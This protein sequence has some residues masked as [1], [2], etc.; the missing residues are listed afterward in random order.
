MEYKR[1]MVTHRLIIFSDVVTSVLLLTA[2]I[3]WA[4]AITTALHADFP[5]RAV[6]AF[7]VYNDFGGEMRIF[8]PR[9]VLEGDSDAAA[10]SRQDDHQDLYVL[11]ALNSALRIYDSLRLSSLVVRAAAVLGMMVS[12]I[13][14]SSA[15]G[16]LQKLAYTLKGA[17][18]PILEL[19]ISL[20]V[21]GSLMAS[22][23][24]TLYFD[25]SQDMSYMRSTL[26]TITGYGV[27]GW[28]DAFFAKI[29]VPSMEFTK[30]ESHVVI[31]VIRYLTPMLMY[32]LYSRLTI[33]TI[34]LS[35]RRVKHKLRTR[36]ADETYTS[37]WKM[38]YEAYG[39]YWP[40]PTKASRAQRVVMCLKAAQNT[41]NL[42]GLIRTIQQAA[43]RKQSKSES[44][45]SPKQ[46]RQMLNVV[47]PPDVVRFVRTFH[48]GISASKAPLGRWSIRIRR[49]GHEETYDV[50]ELMQVIIFARQ[51]C[52]NEARLDT[53]Q[54]NST[55][56]ASHFHRVLHQC[57]QVSNEVSCL[58]A[59]LSDVMADVA[60]ASDRQSNSYM[61]IAPCVGSAVLGHTHRE[62]LQHQAQ[63]G[64]SSAENTPHDMQGNTCND[65]AYTFS[66]LYGA[67]RNP[68][69]TDSAL[70]MGRASSTASVQS[71][72]ALASM[73]SLP[74]SAAAMLTQPGNHT[75]AR[76]SPVVH[77]LPGIIE[78]SAQSARCNSSEPSVVYME[79]GSDTGSDNA[80]VRERYVSSASTE[81]DRTRTSIDLMS[82]LGLQVAASLMHNAQQHN[83]STQGPVG[84]GVAPNDLG[85]TVQQRSHRGPITQTV[86]SVYGNKPM[87]PKRH[88]K[89]VKQQPLKI[90]Q[91]RKVTTHT[92]DSG[93]P[94]L[95]TASGQVL[96]PRNHGTDSNP[97][98]AQQVHNMQQQIDQ[99]TSQLSLPGPM[100]KHMAEES[101]PTSAAT[102][103]YNAVAR[104]PLPYPQEDGTDTETSDEPSPEG[105]SPSFPHVSVLPQT[106]HSA[107][108]R[109]PSGSLT[110]AGTL[111]HPLAQFFPELAPQY[112][113]PGHTQQSLVKHRMFNVTDTGPASPKVMSN[114]WIQ[115]QQN[116]IRGPVIHG[117]S[118]G[119]LS[120]AISLNTVFSFG[121]HLGMK[122]DGLAMQAAASRRDRTKEQC[123]AATRRRRHKSSVQRVR[124]VMRRIAI[125]SRFTQAIDDATNA[126]ASMAHVLAMLSQL[127]KW[128]CEQLASRPLQ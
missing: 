114:P 76:L 46:L 96:E 20:G 7:Q 29:Q 55:I 31:A 79:K 6:Q 14:A 43:L 95:I 123:R 10:W 39:V 9:K 16:P 74:Y 120:Q 50:R 3:L 94:G 109:L 40:R 127:H 98:Q 18:L 23:I 45:K 102:W 60:M 82:S 15:F 92:I 49:H 52:D 89:G 28:F 119:M 69:H 5:G 68:T 118:I 117:H 51:A 35:F 116:T 26:N 105:K 64:S 107:T 48:N 101:D 27:S 111:R 126:L 47:V 56:S 24:S 22:F 4:A 59:D 34:L 37:T 38:L 85:W 77:P 63:T 42:P 17:L 88:K 65:P 100:R 25:A 99:L 115:V 73:T 2:D 62:Q 41:P 81:A 11:A 122:A 84:E 57:R 124:S 91:D 93:I 110:Y 87:K 103:E 80:N 36:E 12:F 112:S 70:S 75:P 54:S 32:L 97:G 83:P 71:L 8:M 72:S 33:T 21:V 66:A 128:Q 13:L 44:F 125:Y 121:A 106:S 86:K 58:M 61:P 53:P 19:V 1:A 108:R 78:A 67:V 90:R 30:F 104:T 113:N